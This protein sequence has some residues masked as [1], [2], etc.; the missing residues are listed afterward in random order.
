MMRDRLIELREIYRR[1]L[2]DSVIPF[3]L[4]HS[5]DHVNGGQFN[6]L[7]RDGT[8]FDTDKSM[9]LQGRALWMFAK[10]YNEVEQRQAWLDAARHIYDFIMRHGFDSD[11]RMFFAVTADGRPLRKRRYLFTETFAVI[12]WQNTPAPPATVPPCSERST[13]I[14]WSSITCANRANWSPRFS[15]G[16]AAPK[17]ITSR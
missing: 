11:G 6:S 12:G 8:V 7:D 5:L 3:W 2:F 9:W 13:P 17:R 14:G 10:L 1:E 15:R 16:R 4:N